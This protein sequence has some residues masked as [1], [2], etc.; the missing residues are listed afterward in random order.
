MRLDGPQSRHGRFWRR[1]KSLATTTIRTP[2][3]PSRSHYSDYDAPAPTVFKF[4]NK[5]KYF[6]LFDGFSLLF[7]QLKYVSVSYQ[8]HFCRK[9]FKT[10]FTLSFVYPSAAEILFLKATCASCTSDVRQQRCGHSSRTFRITRL[11]GVA[12]RVKF[13]NEFCPQT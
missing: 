5:I 11:W 12:Q 10:P 8:S 6:S 9:S 1:E 7:I 2:D 13:K 3:R 4:I